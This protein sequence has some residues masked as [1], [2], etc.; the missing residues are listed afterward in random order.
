MSTSRPDHLTGATFAAARVLEP[1]DAE[2]A[3]VLARLPDDGPR[4][5]R[6]RRLVSLVLASGLVVATVG[7]AG[8]ATGLLP[9]GAE[10]PAPGDVPGAGEPRYS[11]NQ[12]VVGT[13]KLR[14]AGRWQMTMS[15]SDQGR[16]LGLGLVDTRDRAQQLICGITSFDAVSI[17]GGSDLPDTT[18]VWGPAPNR[19]AAVRVTAPGGFRRTA[20]AFD[21]SS[22]MGGGFYVIEIPRQGIVNAEV[23]WL[24]E[25]GRSK[26]SGIYVP[27]TVSFDSPPTEQQPPH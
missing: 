16:C 26:G 14:S 24:D 5:A 19:A 4:A 25:R 8:A 11:A 9:V 6:R 21:G 7:V 2:V 17:G 1:T 22:A 23:T 27:S 10:L 12:V 13:G 20:A 15:G 18:V 3:R